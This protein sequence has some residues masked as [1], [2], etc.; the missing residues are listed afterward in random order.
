MLQDKDRIFKNL[1]GFHDWGLEGARARG[2]WDG[3]K[4][5]LEKGFR[6]VDYVEARNA[7]TLAP[8]ASA[9]EPGRLLAAAYLGRARLI[10]NV[11]IPT[12]K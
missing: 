6:Q 2:S 1:Y 8:L 7:D 10:D 4:A 11:A 9:K 3:T 12:Q 5:L